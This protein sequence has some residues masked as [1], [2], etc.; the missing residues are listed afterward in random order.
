L[1]APLDPVLNKKWRKKR[2]K[3]M[4]GNKNPMFGKNHTDR[5]KEKIV[6][7]QI[8]GFIIQNIKYVDDELAFNIRHL[9]KYYEWR[10]AIFF[11]DKY[12][13]K[14]SGEKGR[15]EA[16]HL[17]PMLF[18]LMDNNITTISEAL[19]CEELWDIDNGVTLLKENHQLLHKYY[20]QIQ[21]NNEV[22]GIQSNI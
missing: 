22:I 15:L 10:S 21:K 1:S 19:A 13:D 18:I 14:Y 8:G 2:S 9:H 16:H 20:R 4:K 6:E 17:K 3:N 7:F 12:K 5:T 11:R